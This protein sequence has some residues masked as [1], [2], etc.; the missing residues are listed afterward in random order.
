MSL[1]N[2]KRQLSP[3]AQKMGVLQEFKT[4]RGRIIRMVRWSHSYLKNT[5]G[6][7][8]GRGYRHLYKMDAGGLP[9][10]FG[11]YDKTPFSRDNCRVLAMAM[12]CEKDWRPKA[13]HCPVKLGVFEWGD[14]VIGKPVF[15]QF[16]E[17]ATWSWQQGCMLQWHPMDADQL[18]LYNRLVDGR[19]GSVV[20]NVC[21]KQIMTSYRMPVYAVDPAGQYGVSLN[22]SRLERLRPGYGYRNL[23][24][25]T[26]SDLCPGNDGIWRIDLGTGECHMF[27]SLREIADLMPQVSMRNAHHYVN[28]PLFSPDGT[29]I[30]FLHL[31]LS[32]GRRCSRM[33]L[34]SFDDDSLRI[35]DDAASVTHYSW[36][37]TT[38]LVCYRVPH[39]Q[40]AGY[41]LL[42]LESGR[43]S[44]PIAMGGEMPVK[45]GH[46]SACPSGGFIVTDTYPDRAGD[47]RLYVCS[48]PERT[49]H[50]V[51]SFFSPFRYRGPVRCDLHPRWDRMGRCIC[52]DSTHEG[53]RAIYVAEVSMPTGT[54]RTC[55]KVI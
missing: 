29:S 2:L 16:A 51:G 49:L 32:D 14:V 4:V 39:D 43:S 10:W 47:Q 22:F 23:P 41:Y 1:T 37:S 52:F 48:I 25:G 44:Q 54:A 8:S 30:V 3:I 38:Q 6:Q 13:A 26:R 35:V 27:R 5:R 20:Q 19:Y 7:P 50:E 45:D 24:D 53:R 42:T 36:L 33:M 46:P 11:Y 55:A 40:P 18:V 15:R 12:I 17:S 28:V 34:Y 31:W 9:T 21:T